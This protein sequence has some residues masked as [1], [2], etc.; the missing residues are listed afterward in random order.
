[1]AARLKIFEDGMAGR[2]SDGILVRASTLVQ[3]G[4]S[5][6]DEFALQQRFLE[7]LQS[8]VGAANPG[9]LVPA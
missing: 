7:D 2:I 4:A 1:L 6:A 9:L 3:E 8:A 5:Q